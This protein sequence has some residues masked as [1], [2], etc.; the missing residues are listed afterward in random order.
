MENN[1]RSYIRDIYIVSLN[2]EYPWK[3]TDG[4]IMAATVSW[5]PD[6]EKLAYTGYKQFGHN[7]RGWRNSE[8]WLT[9]P[10]GGSLENLTAAFDRT[11]LA[12]FKGP[13]WSSDSKTLF[14]TAPNHGSTHIYK[15]DINSR[16][17]EPVVTGKRALIAY[18]IAKDGSFI[19]FVSTEPTKPDEIWLH[20]IQGAK[21]LTNINSGLFETLEL[22]D[23]EEF[24]FQASDGEKIQGWVMK[25]LC[26]DRN[27]KF[28]TVI[29]VHGGPMGFHGYGF[30]HGFQVLAR[31]GYVV[32]YMNP[33]MSTGYGEKFAAECCGHYGEKDYND[34]MEAI[35]YVVATYPYVDENKLGIE[36]HSYGGF[37]MNWIVGHTDRFKACVSMASISNWDS[38]FGVSDI[39][40]FWVP[41]QVGFGKDP[42][43]DRA[44]HS[45]KSPFSYAGRVNTPILFMHPEKDY[46]CPLDQSEQYYVALKKLG[47]ETELIIFPEEHHLLPVSGKPSH[48]RE[49][50]RHKLRWFEK[51]LK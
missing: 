3:V 34:I 11:I 1:D 17:V 12:R 4:S 21:Q 14:F 9:H 10:D 19:A 23:P 45:E 44:L 49:W 31:H 26:F 36:G 15:V 41:W 46:R 30:N 28:P 25:P 6:G 24:W 20:D 33:R 16:K 47:V 38:F 2:G 5:S 40:T 29:N 48:R 39:G 43:D 13:S 37:V 22:I 8:I 32:V 50:L 51:Y 27:E 7:N 18:D 42:W 35:D